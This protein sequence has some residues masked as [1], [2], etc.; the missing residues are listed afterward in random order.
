[1]EPTV[2]RGILWG[3]VSSL[4][5]VVLLLGYR[6]ITSVV[7]VSLPVLIGGGVGVGVVTA[8]LSYAIDTRLG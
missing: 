3:I 8:G 6:L 5:F 4:L 2:Q 1:M 7:V